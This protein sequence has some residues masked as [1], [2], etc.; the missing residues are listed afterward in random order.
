MKSCPCRELNLCFFSVQAVADSLY[1]LNYRGSYFAKIS[2]EGW[3]VLRCWLL[4]RRY[5]PSKRWQLFGG[6]HGVA[7]QENW[8]FIITALRT[9]NLARLRSFN[10]ALFIT[11]A[12]L[13]IFAL[14]DSSELSAALTPHPPVPAIYRLKNYE[15]LGA[16]AKLRKGTVRFVMSVRLHGTS[17]LSVDESSWNLTICRISAGKVQGS[18]NF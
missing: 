6:L 11:K 18:L 15:F 9:S 2:V 1:R 8:I 14:R 13:A 17:P 16:L 4:K 10:G 12:E 7:S 5:A 3:C